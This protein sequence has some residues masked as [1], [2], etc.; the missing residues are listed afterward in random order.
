MRAVIEPLLA[1]Q[2]LGEV[3]NDDRQ[4]L[5]DLGLVARHPSGAG[6]CHWLRPDGSVFALWGC[7]PGDGVKS[8]AGGATRSAEGGDG[9]VGPLPDGIRVKHRV[10]GDI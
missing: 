7:D 3:P 9:A 4:F 1:G 5:V 6:I 10:A 2:E 8:V